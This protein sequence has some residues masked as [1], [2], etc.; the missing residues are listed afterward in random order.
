[1]E[2][3]DAS[4]DSEKTA[5]KVDEVS[6]AL[7]NE[8]PE[9]L[10]VSPGWGAIKLYQKTKIG[11]HNVWVN[12]DDAGQSGKAEQ[13]EG[14]EAGKAEQEADVEPALVEQAVEQAVEPWDP[15]PCAWRDLVVRIVDQ[16]ILT[17]TDAKKHFKVNGAFDPSLSQR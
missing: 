15:Y 13:A 3:E 1:M 6:D 5:G 14:A 8:G 9:L 12:V 11:V 17:K 2:K 4:A 16:P 10:K 7:G